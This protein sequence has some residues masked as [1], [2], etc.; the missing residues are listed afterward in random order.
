[1]ISIATEDNTFPA[2]RILVLA[3]LHV[4]GDVGKVALYAG[5][6]ILSRVAAGLATVFF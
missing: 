5:G 1:V 6:K 4:A 3:A 2:A